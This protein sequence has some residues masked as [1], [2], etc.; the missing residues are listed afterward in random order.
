MIQSSELQTHNTKTESIIFLQTPTKNLKARR[1]Q[2]RAFQTSEWA[3]VG[4][5]RAVL[6]NT[7]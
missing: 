2:Q 6:E 4:A 5:E 7:Q 1:V 3:E